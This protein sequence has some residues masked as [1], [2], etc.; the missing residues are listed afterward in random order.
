MLRRRERS[1]VRASG[2]PFFL[3]KIRQ[4]LRVVNGSEKSTEA[5]DKALACASINSAKNLNYAN[6]G[7]ID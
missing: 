1:Q 4:V 3:I 2:N 7:K 6:S 5:C